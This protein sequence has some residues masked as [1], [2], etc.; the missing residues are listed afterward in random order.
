[1]SS[2]V[3]NFCFR[4]RSMIA[5]VIICLT[6]LTDSVIVTFAAVQGLKYIYPNNKIQPFFKHTYLAS[7]TIFA[8]FLTLLACANLIC[9]TNDSTTFL[10]VFIPV[11]L[12]GFLGQ[13]SIL[14]QIIGRVY[15]TFFS[16][17]YEL[18]ENEFKKLRI[19]CSISMCLN[20]CSLLCI[21]IDESG[22]NGA[23]KP[24]RWL[25]IAS[26]FMTLSLIYYI[27][28]FVKTIRIFTSKIFKLAVNAMNSVRDVTAIKNISVNA[29]QQKFLYTIT[30]HMLLAMTKL[31]LTLMTMLI[32]IIMGIYMFSITLSNS[33]THQQR[34]IAATRGFTAFGLAALF[35]IG[36]TVLCMYMHYAFADKVYQ[37]LCGKCHSLLARKWYRKVH[38]EMTDRNCH[39]DIKYLS[40]MSNMS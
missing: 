9:F 19:H 31:S 34:L 10:I 8:I 13:H 39:K 3:E 37:K 24:L 21:I 27:V 20:I 38:M 26:L 1:M 18:S 15:W 17:S 33:A 28:L 29:S 35:D 12:S 40:N 16:S 7:I 14:Y 2:L 5:V 36:L 22:Y 11:L 4:E 32:L 25:L 30:K 23:I 6:L